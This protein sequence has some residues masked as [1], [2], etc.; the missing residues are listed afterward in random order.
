MGL[1]EDAGDDD[2]VH[3]LSQFH[4]KKKLQW[5]PT[6]WYIDFLPFV[7]ARYVLVFMLFLGLCNVYALRVNLSVAIVQMTAKHPQHGQRSFDWSNTEEGWVLSSFFYGYMVSQLPGGWLAT[8]IGGKYVFGVGVLVTS[9]LTLITP[10][11]AYLNLWAL[12]SC[13]VVMGFFEGVTF[14]AWNAML[15]KWAPPME[16]SV[17]ATIV[18]SGLNIGNIV[19]FPLSGVL[20]DTMGWPW[21]F[22]CFGF[23]G[24]LWFVA[25]LFLAFNTPA[26]HP[27]ISPQEQHY[28]ESTI[29][30]ELLLNKNTSKDLSTPW[31]EIF[32]SPPFLG[33]ILAHVSGLWFF[34][35]LLTCLPTFLDQTLCLDIKKNGFY[36]AIPYVCIIVVGIS[37][38][39]VTDLLRQRKLVTTT[40]IRKI[41]TVLGGFLSAIFLLLCGYFGNTTKWAIAFLSLSLGLSGLGT[42]GAVINNL[43][44]A[45]K[46]AGILFGISNTFGTIPGFVG[47]QVAKAIAKKPS[48]ETCNDSCEDPTSIDVYRQE[49]R[50]VFIIAA[51]IYV[52][53]ALAY[54]LLGSGEKQWWADGVAHGDNKKTIQISSPSLSSIPKDMSSNDS[55]KNTYTNKECN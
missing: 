30:A 43:D 2:T 45:P 5:A 32:T 24:I 41:N 53:G 28:I 6:C 13:R 1:D 52:F 42:A 17:M 21:V 4:K 38:G 12:V 33:I 27:R 34:Y 10:Q 22:Y 48:F 18:M 50:L 23:A 15:G 49:W 26:S 20:C 16:R 54:L 55:N 29:E 39:Q 7:K 14:P 19:A 31:K 25:W 37:W 47:P 35:T 46:Y 51:Q 36:S 11:M 40:V 3:L 8:K 44:I 9:L